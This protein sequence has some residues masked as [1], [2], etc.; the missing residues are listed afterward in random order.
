MANAG[1]TVSFHAE[2]SPERD[3]TAQR[4]MPDRSGSYPPGQEKE[5]PPKYATLLL[6]RRQQY[7]LEPQTI[8]PRETERLN[9]RFRQVQCLVLA[10]Q[11]LNYRSSRHSGV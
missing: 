4:L 2:A 6:H 8:Q 9:Y 11:D 3:Q 7:I 1:K 10:E 5:L